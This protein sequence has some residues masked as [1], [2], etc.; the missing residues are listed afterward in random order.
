MTSAQAFD[1]AV[2]NWHRSLTGT[3]PHD[4]IGAEKFAQLIAGLPTALRLA[5]R[6]QHGAEHRPGDMTDDTLT[7]GYIAARVALAL[8]WQQR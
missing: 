7:E 4:S 6:V 2:A 1:L 5:W 3:P 8:A